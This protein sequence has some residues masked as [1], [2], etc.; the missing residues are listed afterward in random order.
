MFGQLQRLMQLL[1][2]Y[3]KIMIIYSDNDDDKQIRLDY[4]YTYVY[5]HFFFCE[6]KMPY[7][8]I[9]SWIIVYIY[10]SAQVFCMFVFLFVYTLRLISVWCENNQRIKPVYFSSFLISF[11]QFYSLDIILIVF[12]NIY[13]KKEKEAIFIFLCTSLR[14]QLFFFLLK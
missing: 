1:H 14:V 2:I 13:S 7:N 10:I 6:L 11:F 9:Y 12:L 5:L 8:N 4:M 3:N